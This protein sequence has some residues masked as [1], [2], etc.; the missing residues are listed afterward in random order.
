MLPKLRPVAAVPA[1]DST[2]WALSIVSHSDSLFTLFHWMLDFSLAP[3]LQLVSVQE[4]SIHTSFLPLFQLAL[5]GVL[6]VQSLHNRLQ[7]SVLTWQ[8]ALNSKQLG[9]LAK[10]A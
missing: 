9:N 8:C 3:W 7:K 5:V 6:V 1:Y 4:N 2:H 10:T